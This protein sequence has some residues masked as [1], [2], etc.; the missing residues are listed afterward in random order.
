MQSIVSHS[1]PAR[2]DSSPRLDDGV[3]GPSR[4][5][6][7]LLISLHREAC[8]ACAVDRESMSPNRTL[9]S[10]LAFGAA[11]AG[12]REDAPPRPWQAELVGA[13]AVRADG[14]SV[15][16]ARNRPLLTLDGSFDGRWRVRLD[17]RPLVFDVARRGP[18]TLIRIEAP[19][20]PADGALCLD[21]PPHSQC[22]PV[23]FAALPG[24]RPEIAALD[25]LDPEAIGERA[26]GMAQRDRI[27]AWQAQARALR[28]AGRVDAA[29]DAWIRAAEAGRAAGLERE[30]A[31]ALRAAG[32]MAY[33][34]ADYR[35]AEALFDAAADLLGDRATSADR[36]RDDY[37]RGVLALALSRFRTATLHFERVTEQA[38]LTGDDALFAMGVEVLALALVEQGR[39][40]D[41]LKTIADDR[42]AAVNAE[43]SP[44]GRAAHLINR[45]WIGLL[46]VSSRA[47]DRGALERARRDLSDAAPLVDRAHDRRAIQ[48]NRAW[49]GLVADDLADARAA[50]DGVAVDANDAD[51]E[52]IRG[53]IALRDGALDAAEAAFTR[54]AATLSRTAAGLPTDNTWRAAHGLGRI[55]AARGES[56]KALAHFRRAL[57]ALD[58]VGTQ[59]G[60]WH[61]RARFYADRRPLVDD[62][63]QLLLETGAVAEAFAVVDGANARALRALE[64]RTRLDRLSTEQRGAW[65][66]HRARFAAARQ[67][68]DA[69]RDEGE[70]LGPEKKAA[71]Q[72]AQQTRQREMVA[73]FEA[74]EALLSREAPT[75]ITAIDAGAI[76]EALKPDTALAAFGRIGE[77]VYGFWLAPGQPIAHVVVG[78]APDPEALRAAFADRLDALTHL[79]VVPGDVPAAREL[80]TTIHRGAPLGTR[81]SLSD[82][83]YA[84]L[85]LRPGAAAVGPPLIVADPTIDL[86]HARSEG[87]AVARLLPDARLLVRAEATREA[88]RAAM[89]GARAMHY[90]GHG[91]ARAESPWQ[92]HLALAGE[93]TLTVADILTADVP[94]GTVV[95]SGCRTGVRGALSDREAIGLADAFVAAGSRAVL[96]TRRNIPDDAA[97]RFIARFHAEGG[98]DRPGAALMAATAAFHRDG[99]PIWSAFRLTGHP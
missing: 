82:L 34:A 2:T 24:A 5:T 62:A 11:S 56:A 70:L 29:V 75:R 91:V 35:R 87:E 39:T 78:N 16:D 58:A 51:A 60:V 40:A 89:A 37:Y 48:V 76:A 83:A 9:L 93:T 3:L 21:R 43:R 18:R 61:A 90:A 41:A 14:I 25:G 73:A 64:A 46:A 79:Y 20:A 26:R 72:A 15:F 97:A 6:G 45:A 99:D 96:A 36:L 80:S 88:V 23:S 17:Q 31:R 52:L 28:Q 81:L 66:A 59:A 69:A 8:P 30:A 13:R 47:V 77:R 42:L 85:V 7:H 22:W 94:A 57:A 33:K 65:E 44:A 71:W 4:P 84:G 10:L 49:L 86:P 63:V 92:A 74:A 68:W 53:E 95:L 32:F 54:A 50:I 27:W 1:G 12:C 98:L 67:A 55:A 19:D 38:W